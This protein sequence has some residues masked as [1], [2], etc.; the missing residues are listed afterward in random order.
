MKQPINVLANVFLA[1][2]FHGDA[3]LTMVAPMGSKQ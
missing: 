2:R 3:S 1:S